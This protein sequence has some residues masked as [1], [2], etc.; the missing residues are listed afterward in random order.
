MNWNSEHSKRVP[1]AYTGRPE[2]AKVVIFSRFPGKS[3]DLAERLL[4][5]VL[6]GTTNAFFIISLRLN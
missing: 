2:D 6:G 5:R 3:F 4:V 1:V